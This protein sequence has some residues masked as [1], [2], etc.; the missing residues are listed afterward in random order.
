MK[1]L[2]VLKTSDGKYVANAIGNI[3]EVIETGT[4]TS[5][6]LVLTTDISKARGLIQLNMNNI[7]KYKLIPVVVGLNDKNELVE[8][9]QVYDG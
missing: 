8:L 9:G 3:K 1:T 4:S 2:Y 7:R 6:K 5:V